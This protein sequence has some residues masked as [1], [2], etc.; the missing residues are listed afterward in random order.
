MRRTALTILAAVF[1]FSSTELHQLVK[2]PGL[3]HHLREHQESDPSMS[4]LG[5]LQLHYTADHPMDNDDADDNE[6]PFKDLNTIGH[7]DSPVATAR[8]E[9]RNCPEFQVVSTPIMHPE[10]IPQYRTFAVFHPPKA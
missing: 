8:L 10:G 7:L 1:L 6:L 9:H 4:L 3:V 2:L 5:F